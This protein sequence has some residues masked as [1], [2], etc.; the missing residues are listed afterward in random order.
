MARD[1]ASA[2]L[3]GDASPAELV[4]LDAH[5]AGCA[6][7]RAYALRVDGLNRALRVRPAEPVPDLSATIVARAH[8]P[9]PGRGEWVRWAL[10]V[11]AA[12]QLALALPSL[13]FG[14]DAGAPVHVARHVGSLSVALAVGLLYAAWRPERAYGLVPVALALAA[15]TA[16]TAVLDVVDGSARALGEAHHL[17]E[18]TAL[19]L[20]WRLAGA[21]RP[22]PRPRTR[23]RSGPRI[24]PTLAAG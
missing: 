1:L 23:T 24:R 2:R 12:T 8:P 20:L 16:V 5:L 14:D 17:L 10:V 11:V 7:C 15:C 18:V 6:H 9:T 22:R 19:V 4:A 21:P 3:D 13:V